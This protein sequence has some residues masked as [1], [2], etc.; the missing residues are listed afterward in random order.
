M[1]RG[2]TAGSIGIRL[3]PKLAS[4]AGMRGTITSQVMD[5]RNN[6]NSAYRD[7][8]TTTAAGTTLRSGGNGYTRYPGQP[9]K[10]S[11]E[12]VLGQTLNKF[13]LGEQ[14]KN[15]LKQISGVEYYK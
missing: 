6:S 11:Q 1:P 9:F 14:D 8:D 7:A 12:S 13:E 5:R 15:K 3:N 2:Q 4:Q 10:V